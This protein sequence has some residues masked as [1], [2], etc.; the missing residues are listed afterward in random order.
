MDSPEQI[1]TLVE[2]L[3]RDRIGTALFGDNK[4]KPTI[5]RFEILGL[6]GRGG[7]GEVLDARDPTLDRPVALKLL[8]RHA[9]E[10]Q[11]RLLREAQALA[12]L[13]HPIVVQVYEV[14]LVGQRLFV[15]MERLRGQT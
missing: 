11:P 9:A 2:V 4:P 5:G 1:D 10:L 14:G 8:Q 3:R 12:R 13:S 15:A 7:M 6:L